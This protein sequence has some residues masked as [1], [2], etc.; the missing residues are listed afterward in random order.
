MFCG[1][2]FDGYFIFISILQ[3]ANGERL[4]IQIKVVFSGK[5]EKF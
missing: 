1:N 5:G 4:M 2:Q 3:K